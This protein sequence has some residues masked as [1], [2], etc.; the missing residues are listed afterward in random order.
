MLRSA[1]LGV[2]LL[3]APNAM[4]QTRDAAWAAEQQAEGEALFQAQDFVGAEAAHRAALQVRTREADPMGWAESI[5]AAG[6]AQSFR[7]IRTRDVEALAGAVRDYGAALEVYTRTETPDAWARTQNNLA[8]ALVWLAQIRGDGSVT[9]LEGAEAALLSVLQVTT[10]EADPANAGVVLYNIGTVQE[11][12]GDRLEGPAQHTKHREACDTY[13]RALD[14]LRR[15]GNFGYASEV[16]R[17]VSPFMN[18][19]AAAEEG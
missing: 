7:G 5:A 16:E 14:A 11:R 15:G 8:T 2:A 6:A 18:R 19:V 10:L 17:R 4:A 1:V 3:L 13:A 12:I 9:E